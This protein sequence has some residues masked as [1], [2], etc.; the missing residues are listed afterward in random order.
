MDKYHAPDSKKN[1]LTEALNLKS[2]IIR[3][4]DGDFKIRKNGRLTMVIDAGN[5]NE[6]R[7]RVT[8]LQN[9]K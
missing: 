9:S 3:T 2:R 8:P 1:R 7:V 6:E 4:E 5:E